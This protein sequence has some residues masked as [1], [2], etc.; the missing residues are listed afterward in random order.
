MLDLL[1]IFVAVF[2]FIGFSATSFV[3]LFFA[4]KIHGKKFSISW[5]VLAVGNVLLGWSYLII[6]TTIE[7]FVLS[8]FHIALIVASMAFIMIGMIS[9]FSEKT[10]EITSLRNRYNDINEGLEYLRTKFM[11]REISEEELKELHKDFIR[12]M[13]E[14]EVKLRK[15]GG[16]DGEGTGKADP[17]EE[18]S[19]DADGT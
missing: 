9:V 19:E 10:A 7:N 16:K 6:L 3:L 15:T 1:T 17:P 13:T 14:I 4:R 8:A 2:V 18:S 12:E 5:I 11:K